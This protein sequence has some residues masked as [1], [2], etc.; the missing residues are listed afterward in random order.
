MTLTLQQDGAPAHHAHQTIEL[1][2]RETPKFIRSHLW[3]PNSPELNPANYHIW[4]VMQDC[5]CQTSIQD[6]NLRQ[7]LVDIWSGFT[8]SI[9]DDAI[10]EWHKR[11]QA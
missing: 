4:G 1:L 5:V 2:L 6:V 11:L 9:V 7:C 8:Q 10:D 3:M